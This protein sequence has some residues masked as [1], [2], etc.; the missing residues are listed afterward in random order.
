MSRTATMTTPRRLAD[1]ITGRVVHPSDPDWD[2][3]RRGF[4]LTVDLRPAAVAF[5][6][7]AREVVAVVDYARERGLR[8]AP[9]STG[10]N[11]G[12]L[13][14]LEGTVLVNVRELAD[15]SIDPIAQ[16]AS[17]PSR[18]ARI[19]SASIRDVDVAI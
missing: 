15:V 18:S 3:S 5:P 6:R 11:A 17:E 8:I 2:D 10:H 14:S 12:P 7:D 9:Q 13:A 16:L 1:R 19:R 4:D